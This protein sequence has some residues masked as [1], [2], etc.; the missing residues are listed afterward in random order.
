MNRRQMLAAS[1]ASIALAAG[2]L[3][4]AG[5]R[6]AGPGPLPARRPP[7][8]PAPRQDL[9][10]ARAAM[11]LKHSVARWCYGGIGLDELCRQAA[12]L[13]AS[14]VELLDEADWGV[15]AQHGLACALAFGPD[16]I[17]K[18]W[19][20]LE[21]HDD[22]VARGEAL[23]PRIAAAG[24]PNMIAFSGNREGQADAEG[25]RHC[26]PG[27]RR[28]APAAEKAGVTIVLEFLN[29]KVDHGDY[30]FDHMAYGADVV[31]GVGSDR[32]RI[33]YDIYHAQIMEG[34]VIRT[35]R[36]HAAHIGHFHTGGVPGRHEIDG[37]QELNYGAIARAIAETGYGGYVGHEFVPAR[38][39]LSSLREAIAICE[40]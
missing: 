17:P 40:A 20:R 32:V 1:T 21:H 28:L 10:P 38:D 26:V 4:S 11:R 30:Q 35:I 24:I 14:S 8:G 25:L 16:T 36:D 15:P 3:R 39:P 33:L 22:L 31:Q 5:A 37:T 6:N 29:S 23:L 34:D 13:G 7:P 27:L 12:L 18:G 9:A 2:W 19:N